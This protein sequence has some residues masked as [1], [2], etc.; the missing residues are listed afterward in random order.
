[1]NQGQG[2][3]WL[4]VDLTFADQLWFFALPYALYVG[5]NALHPWLGRTGAAATGGA[6]SAGALLLFA[7]QK[8]YR[9]RLSLNGGDVGP[10]LLWGLAALI[11]WLGLYWGC[12]RLGTLF[13]GTTAPVNTQDTYSLGY[14]VVRGLASTLVIPFAEELFCRAFC[15]D[16]GSAYGRRNRQSQGLLD[17][18]PE[19]LSQ[20][21]WLGIGALLAGLIFTLGHPLSA[22]PAAAV[23]FAMTQ[24]LYQKTGN[25]FAVIVAHALANGLIALLV[26]KA[27]WHWLW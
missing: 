19:S 21:S 25:L 23:W 26:A 1:M 2:P 14:L 11:A 9:G 4:R 17:S 22:W 18:H 20:T 13:S 5:G 12:L 10:I 27:G 7:M 8:R 24:V 16:L 3:T 15:L 6:L